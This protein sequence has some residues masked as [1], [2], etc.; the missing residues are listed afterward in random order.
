MNGMPLYEWLLMR[1]SRLAVGEDLIE[2]TPGS[3]A[4][5]PTEYK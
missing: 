4:R 3:T 2:R 5:R 1:D